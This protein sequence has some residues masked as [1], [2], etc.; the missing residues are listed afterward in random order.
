MASLI[1]REVCEKN[2][3][4]PLKK[5]DNGLIVAMADPTDFNKLDDLKFITG[6]TIQPVLASQ[7][8]I[9][10]KIKALYGGQILF[11]YRNP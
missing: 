11:P 2:L 9:A 1:P 6:L 7:Q 10:E 8:E 4:V 3:L 5:A